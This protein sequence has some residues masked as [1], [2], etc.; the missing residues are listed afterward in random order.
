MIHTIQLMIWKITA[1]HPSTFK[2]YHLD[3]PTYVVFRLL[4]RPG[5]IF[6]VYF[7]DP[8]LTT[9]AMLITS[10]IALL[11]QLNFRCS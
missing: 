7:C 11:Y 4:V 2:A 5:A 8:H 1:Y 10:G 9:L 6:T 3:W